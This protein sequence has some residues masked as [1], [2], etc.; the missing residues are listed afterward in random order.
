M[1]R[2]TPEKEPKKNAVLRV[3]F[4]PNM[5][6]NYNY[7]YNYC[8]SLLGDG[9]NY[10][11]IMLRDVIQRKNICNTAFLEQL[12]RFLANN[13][14]SLFSLKNIGNFFEKQIC[15]DCLQ[16]GSRICRCVAGG[17]SRPLYRTIRYCRQKMF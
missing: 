4:Q 5:R 6:E 1:T 15:E 17:I 11:T 7:D 10:S 12:I 13:I 16:P 2:R 3:L 14:G 8:Y 9:R